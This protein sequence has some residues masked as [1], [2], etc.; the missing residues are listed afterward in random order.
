MGQGSERV[1]NG[2]FKGMMRTILIL[3]VCVECWGEQVCK[4]ERINGKLTVTECTM[5]TNR[6]VRVVP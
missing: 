4:A 2:G 5:K 3:L 1:C 6:T